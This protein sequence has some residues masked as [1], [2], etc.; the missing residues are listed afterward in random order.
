MNLQKLK[1]RVV[2]GSSN[3]VK[4]LVIVFRS[5]DNLHKRQHKLFVNNSK[6]THFEEHTAVMIIHEGEVLFKQKL[7]KIM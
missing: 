6:V 3:A 4:A 5:E 2:Q 7:A 1:L